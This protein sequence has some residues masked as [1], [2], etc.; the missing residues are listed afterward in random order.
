MKYGRLM[1]KSVLILCI[2]LVVSVAVMADS[3]GPVGEKMTEQV[4]F[5]SVNPERA[6]LAAVIMAVI[7]LVIFCIRNRKMFKY[8]YSVL[9]SKK[10][11]GIHS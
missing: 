2:V 10:T 7:G 6:I 4:V 9:M 1:I 11:S 5:R 8:F 3:S